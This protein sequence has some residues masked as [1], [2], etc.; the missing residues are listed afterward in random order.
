MEKIR[1]AEIIKDNYK[2]YVVL[3][4]GFKKRNIDGDKI[5]KIINISYSAVYVSYATQKGFY[6]TQKKTYQTKQ[7]IEI[8]S[9]LTHQGEFFDEKEIHKLSQS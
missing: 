4:H 2:D 7:G 1:V 5:N 9:I 8:E 6:S 3:P